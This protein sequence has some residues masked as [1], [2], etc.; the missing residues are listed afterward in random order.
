[1]GIKNWNYFWLGLLLLGIE[2]IIAT[3][4]HGT[5]VR[6][7]LGDFLVVILI[8]AGVRAFTLI[9]WQKVALGVL[10]FSYTVEFF[11]WINLLK[12]LGLQRSLTTD[13]VFGS[14]FDWRDIGAYTCG[15]LV[16]ILIEKLVLESK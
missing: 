1:L 4:F 14:S 2:I 15:I 3:F 13:L 5:F 16:V 12:K 10:L 11:Q 9:Q 8:Y 6:H 7:I